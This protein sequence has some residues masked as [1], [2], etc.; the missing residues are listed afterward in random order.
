MSDS[1]TNATRPDATE[2]DGPNATDATVVLSVADAAAA[3]GISAGAVRKR[4]ER[5]QLQGRK[6]AGQWHIIL[7][8]ADLTERPDTT[9]ATNAS[10]KTRQ[11]PSHTTTRE[12]TDR[13]DATRPDASAV[14]S[15]AAR[16]QL[17]AIRDEFITPLVARIEELSRETGRLAEAE[18]WESNRALLAEQERD[19]LRAEVELLREIRQTANVVPF[20]AA[21]DATARPPHLVG[22]SPETTGATEPLIQRLVESEVRAEAAEQEAE[23]LRSLIRSMAQDRAPASPTAPGATE[24]PEST[25]DT[26]SEPSHV[27]SWLRR[28]F[29]RS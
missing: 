26:L 6:V 1:A 28:L 17:E 29:G 22:V 24:P 27:T 12:A 15:Q 4:L 2:H 3:F 14:V 20:R 16:A 18:R 11:L 10:G 5:G 19:E 25:P 8:P 23:Q 7:S 9:N 13:T 21:P